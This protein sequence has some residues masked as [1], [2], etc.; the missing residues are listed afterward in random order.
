MPLSS[1]GE[2]KANNRLTPKNEQERVNTIVKNRRLFDGNFGELSVENIDEG[3]VGITNNLFR[4]ASTFFPEFMYARRPMITV[5]DNE[6][7]TSFFNDEVSTLLPE[8]AE[9]NI[10]MLSLGEGVVA[11]HPL[12]P[13]SFVA[14]APDLHF[15][16]HNRRGENVGDVLIRFRDE[17]IDV[18]K[19]VN[20]GESRW[21]VY[22]N[23]VANLG[24][25][26]R[27]EKMPPRAGR[28]VATIMGNSARRSIFNDM[29]PHVGEMSRSQTALAKTIRR[30]S[31]PHLVLPS[32]AITTN[33][34]GQIEIDSEGMV[35]P[36]Q[37][38]DVDP[39]YLQWD[40]NIEAISWQH[41]ENREAA[42]ISAALAPVL[43]NPDIRLGNVTGRALERLA[44]PFSARLEHYARINETAIEELLVIYNNNR[45]AN[46]LEV[47]AFTPAD[48][49]I[50]WGYRAIFE[51][52][53]EPQQPQQTEQEDGQETTNVDE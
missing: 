48:I 44:A 40:S 11:S 31:N 18:F 38:G 46:G 35:F 10:D 22:E 17:E 20:S 14:F 39:A 53:A 9:A 41:K 8:L 15:E 42:L 36:V 2:I 30:N 51:D 1:F 21:E 5:R 47:F 3:I 27:T 45:G 32:G 13:L 28:Q 52:V 12:D 25:L 43:F 50:E 19:Y 7:L 26:R 37:E 29:K 16:V 23:G 6:R 24:P 4:R 33:E 34:N 49:E